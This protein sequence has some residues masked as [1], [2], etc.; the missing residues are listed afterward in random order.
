MHLDICVK[1][2]VLS[3]LHKN[4]C[5]STKFSTGGHHRLHIQRVKS[6]ANYVYKHK[7]HNCLLK[8]RIIELTNDVQDAVAKGVS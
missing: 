6:Y 4:Y 5:L 7:Y 1:G 2:S 8:Q 3:N